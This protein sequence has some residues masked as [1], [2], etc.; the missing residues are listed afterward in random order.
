MTQQLKQHPLFTLILVLAILGVSGCKTVA[1]T[2]GNPVI[3]PN[4]QAAQSLLDVARHQLDPASRMLAASF[5]DI[6]NLSQSSS[7]GRIASQQ[8]VSSFA[9]EGYQFVEL[10]LRNNVYVDQRQGEFLLSRTLSDISAEHD[11]DVVLVGTYAVAERNIY[12]TARLIRTRDNIILASHDY[13]VPYTPD[14]RRLLRP[15]RW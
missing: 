8:L 5:A 13:A 10:L 14:M 2:I 15:E 7:F 9:A 1:R 6:D 3:T 11:A 12:V 4:H